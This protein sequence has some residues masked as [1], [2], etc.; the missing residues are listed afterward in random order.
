MIDL[1]ILYKNYIH[2]LCTRT[3]VL[4][5]LTN[6][7]RNASNSVIVNPYPASIFDSKMSSAYC[8]C[9]IRSNVPDNF[10]MEANIMNPD[11]TTPK[12]SSLICVH[13]VCNMSY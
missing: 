2:F 3:S 13:I 10:F 8:I 7:H 9:C 12:G 11:Q 6:H 1:L 4:L 5:V